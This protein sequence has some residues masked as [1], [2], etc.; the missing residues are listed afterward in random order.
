[1]SKTE[2]RLV[3]VT[4]AKLQQIFPHPH[5]HHECLTLLLYKLATHPLCSALNKF[6]ISLSTQTRATRTQPN[7]PYFL[8]FHENLSRTLHRPFAEG[9]VWAWVSWK[10]QVVPIS[11]QA[12]AEGVER[13]SLAYT[14]ENIITLERTYRGYLYSFWFSQLLKNSVDVVRA[15]FVHGPLLYFF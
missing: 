1:M 14:T 6:E 5:H 8:S 15:C 7:Q 12:Y 4:L 9:Q 13:G 10:L 2:Q 3:N 11:R